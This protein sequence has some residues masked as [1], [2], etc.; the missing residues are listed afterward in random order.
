MLATQRHKRL[1]SIIL[2]CSLFALGIGGLCYRVASSPSIVPQKRYYQAVFVL[3]KL[4]PI[5]AQEEEI[6]PAAIKFADDCESLLHHTDK[7]LVL[8]HVADELAAVKAEVPKAALFEAHARLALGERKHGSHLLAQYVIENDYSPAHYA[9]LC[10]NLYALRDYAGLL[11]MCREWAERDASCRQDRAQYLWMSL[12]NLNRF[13]DATIALEKNAD[14]LGW[15]AVV[16]SAKTLLAQGKERQAE[17]ILKEAEAQSQ[18]N[19]GQIRRVWERI[20]PQQKV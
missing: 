14:C 20:K 12:Y 3:Q 18:E 6:I 5:A 2:A 16:F 9:L 13:S 11:L 1:F 15:K 4:C 19:A 10:E 17:Q 8:R 7:I